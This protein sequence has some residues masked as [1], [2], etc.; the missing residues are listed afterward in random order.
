MKMNGLPLAALLALGGLVFS[1]PASATAITGGTTS[2]ALNAGTVTALVGLG[3]SIAPVAP[4]TLTGLEAVFPITGGDNTTVIDHDGGL[5]FTKGGTTAD[6]ENFVINLATDKLSGDLVAG[7]VTT[8]NVTFFDVGAG[9][10]LTLD[11]TLAG[12]LSSVYGIPNLTGASIGT[13]T[14]DATTVPEPGSLALLGLGSLVGL[15][16]ASKARSRA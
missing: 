4:A 14:V 13:A 15:V 5:A 1:S 16:A 11:G 6:I 7:G 3:F 12:D 9:G 10:A 2:V 8:H